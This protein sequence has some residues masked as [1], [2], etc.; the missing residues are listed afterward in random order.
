M[1][2]PPEPGIYHF[3]ERSPAGESRA[4]LRIDRDGNGLL[5]VNASR[6]Y[7]FNPTAAFM[8]YMVLR[9]I[10]VD[11]A[12]RSLTRA[13]Q[14]SK[15]QVKTDYDQLAQQIQLVTAPGYDQVARLI[16]SFTMVSDQELCILR[17]WAT[18]VPVDEIKQIT[19][20]LDP[21]DHDE[22]IA[23]I[24]YLSRVGT[25]FRESLL[26]QL[27]QS[28][29]RNLANTLVS[30]ETI[31]PK[32]IEQINAMEFD[33][34]ESDI[35][36]PLFDTI[37]PFSK[38]DLSAPYRM[39]LAI[40]YRCNNRCHHCYNPAQRRREELDTST[41][42]QVIDRLW[43]VGIPH[44]IFTGGEPTLR[45]D[46]PELIA[47]AEAN[48]QITG[49]NT[50]G[51]RLKDKAFLQQLV[52]AG[53]DHIQITIESHDARIHDEMVA[54]AS[55][56]AET[57]SGI[58][59]VAQSRLYFMTNTT[60]LQN[61]Y[62]GLNETLQFLAD[63]GVERVGLNAL[64]YSG[65]GRDVG[66]G[67]PESLLPDLLVIAR[68]KTQANQQ[69]LT[70]YTPT[71][72]CHFDPVLFDF[73]SLGVKGCT[74]ALYNMCVEPDGK[75]LPCQSYYQPLGHILENS[76]EQIWH[77]DLATSLR[78]RDYIAEACKECSLLSVCGGGCPLAYQ[79]GKLTPP[80]SI[81]FLDA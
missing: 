26:A 47:H 39:D 61:N 65:Q 40:T 73:E 72:Y 32:L 2:Q 28:S 62:L 13:Y 42:K 16:K 43:E 68:E 48:G 21:H 10:S 64:I 6:V 23:L 53:L 25:P 60:L 31:D 55:A 12:I 51:R 75:V 7:H 1:V 30:L 22:L 52:S 14:V 66:S 5:M 19:Q 77:S 46:L 67:L 33:Q 35:V 59:N 15:A 74:A 36:D 57:V 58:E 56:W 63:L 38:R 71:Q 81:H 78:N 49:I 4:H 17:D 54:Q 76:W 50:N 9:E 18:K 29:E 24:P 37:L 70:W 27:Q 80:R 8:A 34:P 69:K 45:D 3:R 44:I 41:W 20:F 79:A 11:L